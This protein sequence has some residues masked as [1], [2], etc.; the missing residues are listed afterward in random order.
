MIT[1]YAKTW[2]SLTAA[3]S[4]ASLNDGGPAL[5]GTVTPSGLQRRD[6]LPVTGDVAGAQR[7]SAQRVQA[8][9]GGHE[10]V[11]A[12][13]AF[14]GFGSPAMAELSPRGDVS[15]PYPWRQPV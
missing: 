2:Q 9:L 3:C 8:P 12:M 4:G 10:S 14:D 7:P 5:R 13:R 6:V 11:N 1:I 15:G